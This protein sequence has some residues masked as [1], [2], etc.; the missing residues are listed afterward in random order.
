[1]R[2]NRVQHAEERSHAPGDQKPDNAAANGKHR[3]F[4]QQ[5]LRDPPARSA[6]RRANCQLAL[7]YHAA[8]QEQARDVH[9]TDEEQQADR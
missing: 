8:N 5:L 2:L 4:R 7:T 3:A 6:E 9:A 1:M